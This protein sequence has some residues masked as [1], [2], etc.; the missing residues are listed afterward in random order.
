[1]FETE[2]PVE[3]ANKKHLHLVVGCERGLCGVVGT[4]LPKKVTQVVRQA[5][6]DRPDIT[7]DVVVIGKKSA[8]ILYFGLKAFHFQTCY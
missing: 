8:V 1:M 7:N 2:E 4:N 3:T 5:N 6:K